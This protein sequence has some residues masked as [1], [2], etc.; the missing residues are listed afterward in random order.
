MRGPRTA[1][2]RPR[3]PEASRHRGRSPSPPP[4]RLDRQRQLLRVESVEAA[5]PP[6]GVLGDERERT[7]D[8]GDGLDLAPIVEVLLD[9]R[10]EPPPPSP[11]RARVGVPDPGDGHQ[12][13]VAL[14][15]PPGGDELAHEREHPPGE[16]GLLDR[17]VAHRLDQRQLGLPGGERLQPFAFLDALGSLLGPGRGDLEEAPAEESPEA[18]RV[19]GEL[20]G[21][22]GRAG[23]EDLGPLGRLLRGGGPDRRRG[24]RGRLPVGGDPPVA[25]ERPE[26][27][28]HERP[29]PA[30]GALG[31]P[32][33]FLGPAEPGRA[34]DEPEAEGPGRLVARLAEAIHGLGPERLGVDPIPL[35]LRRVVR[36]ERPG[37][38]PADVGVRALGH[39]DQVAGRRRPAGELPPGQPQRQVAERLAGLAE[40]RLDP[41]EGQ[42]LGRDLRAGVDRPVGL[43]Q[44]DVGVM[45]ADVSDREPGQRRVG[46]SRGVGH[47]PEPARAAEARA[48]RGLGPGVAGEHLEEGGLGDD[49]DVR[50]GRVQLLPLDLLRP[51]LPC[52]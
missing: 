17:Q 20:L 18:L 22:G 24:G 37:H 3:R 11:G 31:E 25:V 27:P 47:L 7:A 44:G 9:G 49:L 33:E 10:H 16:V 14:A 41:V 21:P 43:G 30:V 38:E 2:R 15:P 35:M 1:D 13:G 51:F 4:Q 34:A 12:A 8:P 45:A 39:P 42:E 32:E 23:P 50:P 28:D 46:L 26:G 6:V 29:D 19:R 5:G 48:R 52:P 40:Q 36:Q